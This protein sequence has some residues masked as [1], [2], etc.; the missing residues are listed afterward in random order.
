MAF[1]RTWCTKSSKKPLEWNQ[2]PALVNSPPPESSRKL[3]PICLAYFDIKALIDGE[4][5]VVGLAIREQY[6]LHKMWIDIK[7]TCCGYPI[8]DANEVPS[9]SSLDDKDPSE[10][11]EFEDKYKVNPYS[12]DLDGYNLDG[13]YPNFSDLNNTFGDRGKSAHDVDD[14]ESGDDSEDESNDDVVEEKN[15]H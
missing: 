4:T 10:F 7:D 1:S 14:Y 12:S 2:L 8:K 11:D 9:T 13:S 5:F 3:P 6:S 15:M